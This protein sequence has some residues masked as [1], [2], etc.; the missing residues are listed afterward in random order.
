[1]PRIGLFI[2]HDILNNKKCTLRRDNTVLKTK[3]L[4]SNI[5]KYYKNTNTEPGNVSFSEIEDNSIASVLSPDLSLS[6]ANKK[7]FNPVSL[8][9][10]KQKCKQFNFPPPQNSMA[11]KTKKIHFL[12]EPVGK[13]NI[14]GD[15]NFLF[16]SISLWL[17]GLKKTIQSFARH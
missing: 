12:S 16:R 14:V 15:G 6:L 8:L 13:I 10:M 5:K 3:K 4:I 2:I 1:M 17:S 7:Y 9:W 11:K